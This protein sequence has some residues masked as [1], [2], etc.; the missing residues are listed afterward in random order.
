MTETM[1]QRFVRVASELLDEDERLAV[2]LADISTEP[3]RES[4]AFER[5][6]RRVINVGIREQLMVN[7]AAGMALEGMRPIAHTF[8]PFLVE[9]AFEQVKLGFSHQGVV[10]ILVSAGASYDYAGYGRT[11]QAPEDVALMATLP[12]WRIEVPGHPD[13]AETLLRAAGRSDESFYI[14][15]SEQSN[16]APAIDFPGQLVTRRR[17]GAGSPVVLAVGPM[18]DRVTEAVSP[19]DVTVLYATSVRPVDAAALRAA[20]TAT[21]IVIVE[22]YLEGTSTAEV[23]AVFADR[24]HRLLS[25]G[26][27]R[28][29]HRKYG[30]AAEH[31]R[32]HGLD[33]VGLR[34]RIGEWIAVAEMV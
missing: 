11:H 18:L 12:G 30:T 27:P 2:V 4:G 20:V 8:A 26:V 33:V 9:R 28:I 16:A 17:G 21:D 23:A 24:P 6:R 15:L 31:D 13:E 25:I 29:E 1:R 22:P 7:V 32:A 3:F 19:L 34:R 10:G 5:H 14:R